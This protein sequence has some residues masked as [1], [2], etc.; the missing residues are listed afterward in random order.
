MVVSDELARDVGIPP[1]APAWIAARAE[2][3]EY[4]QRILTGLATPLAKLSEGLGLPL[5]VIEDVS[6]GRP[7]ALLVDDLLL[8]L[9]ELEM[10]VSLSAQPDHTVL[11]E[12][13][14]DIA[15]P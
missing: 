6:N 15:L 1:D 3:V 12:V 4:V 5:P 14:I 8:M 13:G 7:D 11:V 9:R 2:L 10:P